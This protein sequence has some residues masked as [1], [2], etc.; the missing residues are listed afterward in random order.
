MPQYKL[1]ISPT[2]CQ[3]PYT[4]YPILPIHLLSKL[5]MRNLINSYHISS[6]KVYIFHRGLKS[7]K[8]QM[9]QIH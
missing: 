6:D 8:A 1:Q 3:I 4:K 7:E 9:M 2:R 5:G